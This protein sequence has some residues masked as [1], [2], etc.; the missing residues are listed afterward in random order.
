VTRSITFRTV[1]T[2]IASYYKIVMLLDYHISPVVYTVSAQP[3][4]DV[5]HFRLA[6]SFT[7]S[8]TLHR[9]NFQ[10]IDSLDTSLTDMNLIGPRFSSKSLMTEY[11][12]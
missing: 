4:K 8:P 10:A 9:K 3:K 11:T 2:V 7:T 12:R 6:D 5:I 1:T